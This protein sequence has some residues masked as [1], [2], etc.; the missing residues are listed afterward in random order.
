MPSTMQCSTEEI[1]SV[2]HGQ[3]DIKKVAVLAHMVQPLHLLPPHESC[4]RLYLMRDI[5]HSSSS[6]S[7]TS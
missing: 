5:G 1:A 4:L 2:C 7:Y 3:F 6:H